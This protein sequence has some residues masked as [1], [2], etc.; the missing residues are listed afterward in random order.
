[1]KETV[2][3]RKWMLAVCILIMAALVGVSCAKKPPAPVEEPMAPA[4][5]AA[6]VTKEIEPPPAAPVDETPDP[7]SFEME[8]FN[9]WARDQ[10]FIG[11]VYFDFDKYDLKPEA[12]DRLAKNAKFMRDYPTVQV[13]IEGHC[14]ERGTNEYNIAL[15]DRRANA[16]AD[17]LGSLGITGSRM[18]TVSYGEEAPVCRESNEACWA[19]NRRARFVITA[20]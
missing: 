1:M 7:M 12:R 5:P 15:G 19:E 6:P 16:A 3:N 10:G 13:N 18:R 14:D 20:K 17:Y 4:A 11:D 2:M 8:E 9:R